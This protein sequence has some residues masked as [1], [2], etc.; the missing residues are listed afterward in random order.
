MT[1]NNQNETADVAMFARSSLGGNRTEKIE[2][3][4]T[5]D[6]KLDLRRRCNDLGMSESEYLERL[7][8]VAIYGI[9]HVLEC[10]RTRTKMVCGLSGLSQ[11]ARP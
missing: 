4:V 6:M 11:E 7:V 10:E 2:S 5:H 9:D 3:R 1:Q 8:A